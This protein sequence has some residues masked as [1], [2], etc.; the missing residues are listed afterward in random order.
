MADGVDA[1]A[2]GSSRRRGSP[3]HGKPPFSMLQLHGQVPWVIP[4]AGALF[5]VLAVLAR[6]DALPWNRPVTDWFVDQRTPRLH[7]VARSSTQLGP[8]A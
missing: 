1:H 5:L 3:T 2:A 4:V 8:T 7:D 6:F